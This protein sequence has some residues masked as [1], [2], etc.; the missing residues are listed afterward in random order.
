MTI[1]TKISFF[2]KVRNTPT[3]KNILLDNA[4]CLFQL[5]YSKYPLNNFCIILEVLPIYWSFFYN[6][7][8]ELTGHVQ[9]YGT[10]YYTET[11][12]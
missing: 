7:V 8:L 11:G 9:P 12:R 10:A 1:Q 5:D 3:S 6:G 4:T 2:I